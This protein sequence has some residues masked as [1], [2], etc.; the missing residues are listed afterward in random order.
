MSDVDL[1]VCVCR[2]TVRRFVPSV[3]SEC[4]AESSSIN[5]PINQ[6]IHQRGV[7]LSLSSRR[8]RTYH[9]P[10]VRAVRARLLMPLHSHNRRAIGQQW[11]SPHTR[12][13]RRHPPPQKKQEAQLSPSDRAMLLVSSNLA[14]YHATVP[15]LLIR[16]VLAKPMV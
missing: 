15:K 10:S 9:I 6:P 5:Q 16:Q 11:R 8:R 13:Q 12:Q 1:N 7:V 3:S 14:N 4:D 2:Q